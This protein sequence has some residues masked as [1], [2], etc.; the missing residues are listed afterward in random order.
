MKEDRRSIET[1]RNEK[2]HGMRPL[3]ERTKRTIEDDDEE[4]GDE[5]EDEDEDDDKK[6]KYKDN[7]DKINPSLTLK[8][9]AE[10]E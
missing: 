7:D 10:E 1:K 4:D 3:A 8:E 5:D 9:A 6:E 2:S